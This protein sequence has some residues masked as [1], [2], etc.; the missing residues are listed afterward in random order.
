M[1]RASPTGAAA[2]PLR[3]AL[4]TTDNREPFREYHK[5]EPWFGT[6][7]EALLQGFT[8]WPETEIHV[9]S[10]TQQP[11]RASPEKLASNIWFHSLR[12]PK[13]GWLRTGY[14]G[15]IR[16][17]RRK[18]RELQPDL[19]HGQGTERDCALSAVFSGYPNVL[20]I[21][22]NMRL[23][24]EVNR[25]RPFSF[26]WFA[27]R[28]ESFTLPR[29]GGIVCITDYTRRAVADASVPKWVV[30]NAV[31]EA[32]FGITPAPAEPPVILCVGHVTHR[33]NQNAFI[34]ALDRL[35]TRRSF[36]LVCVGLARRGDPYADE[37]L[38]LAAERP[39]VEFA[40]WS[41]R[42]ALRERYRTAALVALPSLEDNCPMAVL[43]AMAAGVPVMAARVG[44]VPELII[45]NGTGVFC[46]PLDESSMADAIERLLT[47][48]A[49]ARRLAGAA[50]ER[51]KRRFHPKAIAGQHLEIYREILCQ[52]AAPLTPP[53]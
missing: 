24:A 22:G 34:R 33:K 15:C 27:A 28:L 16:A 35:A 12:V 38:A 44:G 20:T 4:L 18:V 10:C 29:T 49:D 47:D 8:H 30:P 41:E 50:R 37:F 53:C 26:D 40:G 7:P 45:E 14:Q 11:M 13:L 21:H 39:W 17:V 6:A 52:R 51:A 32:F 1:N 23:I 48:R 42:A 36:R 25:T 5:I 3:I 19:V 9:V 2:R 43:E 31:D 46:D